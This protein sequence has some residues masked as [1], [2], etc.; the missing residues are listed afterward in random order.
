MAGDYEFYASPYADDADD[1]PPRFVPASLEDVMRLGAPEPQLLSGL[2]YP[3]KLHSIS[4]PP[5]SGK[6]IM[7]LRWAVE[8]M[9]R[10][11]NV[12]HIDEEAGPVQTSALLSALGAEPELVGKRFSYLGYPAAGWKGNDLTAL[13]E[14]ITGLHPVLTVWD[15]C[16]AIMA[17]AGLD[18]NSASDV[19][20]FWS[21]VL[22]PVSRRHGCA[23][24]LVDHDAKSTEGTRYSR[25]S[26]AKLASTDVAFKV[27]PV[28]H[29]SR[30]QDGLL[31]FTVA[32][33]RQ[34]YLHRSWRV[35]VS[36]S[37]FAMDFVHDIGDRPAGTDGMSPAAAKLASL[38]ADEPADIKAIIDR[39]AGHY[40]HGMRWPE[41]TAEL[42]YLVAQGVADTIHE[43]GMH[44]MWMRAGA[45]KP[46]NLTWRP[47]GQQPEESA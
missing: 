25:G 33:D 14:L 16:A 46:E 42:N 15:S 9:Q 21:T 43:P 13:D 12:L 40:G 32:K 39:L 36:H 34:G 37:P 35:R 6:T 10:G 23:V 18:E 30:Q 20:R 26:G 5:E 31:K 22:L 38:L 47:T 17:A 24:L 44:Q 29:F 8:V 28:R 2:L 1:A 41:A 3:G 11:G 27:N 19:T 7:C 45:P 4:G